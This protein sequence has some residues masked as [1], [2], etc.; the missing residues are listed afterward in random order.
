MSDEPTYVTHKEL[1]YYLD[2]NFRV[3]NYRLAR[4]CALVRD[5]INQTADS[6][7]RCYAHFELTLLLSAIP[8]DMELE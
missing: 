5:L 2:S 7:L 1:D 8:D 3:L 4:L 6:D